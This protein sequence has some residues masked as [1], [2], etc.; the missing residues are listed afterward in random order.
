MIRPWASALAALTAWLASGGLAAAEPLPVIPAA[1]VPSAPSALLV[2]VTLNGARSGELAMLR[3]LPDGC[4][5]IEAAALRALELHD[6]P[7]DWV[8]LGEVAGLDYRLDPG[9][10]RVDLFAR[11]LAP[12]ASGRKAARPEYAPGITG[13]IGQYGFSAQHVTTREEEYSAAFGDLSLTFH[14][15]HGR[16]IQDQV[17]VWDGDTLAV[18]RLATAYERDFPDEMMRLT[19]GDSFTRAPR[20]GRLSAFAGVQVGTDFSMDPSESFRPYRTFQALLREQAEM[21]VRVNGVVRQRT[22]VEPGFSELLLVPESGHNDIEIAIRDASGLTRIEDLSFFASPEALAAGV[23]EFSASAGV[24]RRFEGR[25]SEYGDTL[26]TSGLVRRGLSDTVTAELHGEAGSGNVLVGGGAQVV[27]GNVG[28]LSIA[29][30]VS[31]RAGLGRGHLVSA[32]LDRSTRRTSL[33][34]QTR[35]A[36]DD[37]A[38]IASG[39][40][41]AYPDVSIRAS[42][43]VF[44]QAGSF[45]ASYTGQ[46]DRVL[47]DR[48]FLSAGW[49]KGMGRG[50]V[51]LSASGFHDFEQAETGATVSLRMTLGAYSGRLRRDQIGGLDVAAIEV[52]RARLAGERAQWSV[53]AADADGASSLR[54][55]LQADIGAADLFVQAGD[56]GPVTEISAGL[57]GGFTIVATHVVMSRQTTPAAALVRVPGV[58]GIPVY[59]DNRRVAV[60]DRNGDAVIPGVRPFEAN[61]VSLRPED[62]PLDFALAQFD[63]E[64]VPRRGIAAVSFEIRRET[65]LAFTVLMPDGAPLPAGSRVELVRAG[66]VCPAGMDGR[67]YCAAADEEDTVRVETQGGAFLAPVRGLRAAGELRLGTGANFRLAGIS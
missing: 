24:P 32:G 29:A 12:E 45:R 50:R 36:D 47:P 23:T 34:L 33:Q 56:Y 20:W 10:A 53:Q 35:I 19:I 64:F 40:G 65:A 57:R 62:L 11:H 7:G 67:V 9:A 31:D 38:D 41:A 15:A 60:T 43:G 59:Q 48:R 39:L 22:S 6:G 13:L 21:E 8:C 55:D 58:A 44:T 26:M 37:Y 49:E 18:E 2:E 14:S 61:R 42:A 27:A 54:G 28:I 46:R 30:A 66:V 3:M 1:A 63:I 16:L 52:S 5:A 17:A 51:T 4:D 25:R